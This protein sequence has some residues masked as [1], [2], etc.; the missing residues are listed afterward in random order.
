MEGARL[1]WHQVGRICTAFCSR[2][3]GG[4]CKGLPAEHVSQVGHL[5][6]SR[7]QPGPHTPAIRV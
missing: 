3:P 1:S 6:R 4:V 7:R 2:M 5:G